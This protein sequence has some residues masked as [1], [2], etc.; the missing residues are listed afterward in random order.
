MSQHIISNNV[1]Q[2]QYSY[3][4]FVNFTAEGEMSPS[5]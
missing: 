2:K 5:Y 3:N 1:Q 4:G